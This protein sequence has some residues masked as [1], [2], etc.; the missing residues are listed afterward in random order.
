LDADL[1]KGFLHLVQLERLDDGFDLFHRDS[2][3]PSID[4]G[5]IDRNRGSMPHAIARTG[6]EYAAI[7]RRLLDAR[8]V[9]CNAV[10]LTGREA[11]EYDP[12]PRRRV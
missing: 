6:Q 4:A 12:S 2:R 1:V 8:R 7:I 5:S 9:A 11:P 10:G 3:P